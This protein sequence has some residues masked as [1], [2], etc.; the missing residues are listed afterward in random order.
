MKNDKHLDAYNRVSRSLLRNFL[1]SSKKNVVFS[2]YSI[3]VLLGILPDATE[4]DT[5]MEILDSLGEKEYSDFIKWL[6]RI[7]K[8]NICL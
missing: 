3:V 2:P 4:S 7:P 1:S 5:R 6:K 8:R